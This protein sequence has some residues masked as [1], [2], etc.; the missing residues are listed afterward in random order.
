MVASFNYIF[1]ILR[2]ATHLWAG[3]PKGRHPGP[4][5]VSEEPGRGEIAPES[6]DGL[7]DYAVVPAVEDV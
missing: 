6:P 5:I 2:R 7:L 4:L 1:E 3:V